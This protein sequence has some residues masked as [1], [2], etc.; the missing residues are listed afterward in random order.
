M[1]MS[2]DYEFFFNASC[3]SSLINFLNSFGAAISPYCIHRM[4]QG[5]TPFN[6]TSR[7]EHQGMINALRSEVEHKKETKTVRF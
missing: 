4:I 3:I 7:L 6:S 2:V 5:L 1:V